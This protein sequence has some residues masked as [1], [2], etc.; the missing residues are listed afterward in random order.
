[1]EKNYNYI[2]TNIKLLREKSKITQKDLAQFLEVDESLIS[3]IENNHCN[4]TTDLLEK[5]ATLFGLPSE[6][7]WQ[8][9]ISATPITFSLKQNEIT[10]E[11][12]EAISKVNKIALNLK[13]MNNLLENSK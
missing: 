6:S 7:F 10:V 2:G 13:F 4:I 8:K 12:L 3:K 1:M 11:N 9:Q 5:V